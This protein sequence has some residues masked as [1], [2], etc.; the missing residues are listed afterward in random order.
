VR[1]EELARG[2][3]TVGPHRDEMRILCNGV[4]L[5]DFGSRGQL[6][7]AILA[8]KLAEVIWLKEKTA[9]WP[10]LLLDETLAELDVER[11]QFLLDYLENVEQA[12]LTTTDLNLFPGD[13]VKKCERWQ[14]NSGSVDMVNE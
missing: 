13:F 11:R 14:I 9:Q 3:T 8:L 10:V 1:G 7:T 5:S 12:I 4:D 2:I 6:R